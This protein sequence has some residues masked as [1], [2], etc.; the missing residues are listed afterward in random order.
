M[1]TVGIPMAIST[2]GH[3]RRSYD[4]FQAARSAQTAQRLLTDDPYLL[5]PGRLLEMITV[6]AAKVMGGDDELGSLE[7]GKRA[8]AVIV[9][10]RQP[11]LVPN[12]M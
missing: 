6:E 10:A 2:D 4:R 1:L 5:P 8:D 12:T 11:H 9:N 3:A 7:A